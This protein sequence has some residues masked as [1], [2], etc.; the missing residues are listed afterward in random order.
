M[1]RFARLL[2][3]ASAVLL[4]PACGEYL[5]NAPEDLPDAAPP[6]EEWGLTIGVSS[7]PETV[8]G[9]GEVTFT[10]T[11]TGG[12]GSYR[13]NW[14]ILDC[15]EDA[16]GREVCTFNQTRAV[17]GGSVI[18]FTRYRRSV[19]TRLRVTVRAWE[20]GGPLYGEAVHSLLGPNDRAD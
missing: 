7:E 2:L 11:A 13:W 15:H 1:R 10:A 6:R 17:E 8:T 9:E 18:S 3:V 19:D 20:M 12:A 16:S 14:S 5:P 4:V